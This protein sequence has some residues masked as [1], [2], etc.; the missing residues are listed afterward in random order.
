MIKDLHYYNEKYCKK[1]IKY[2]FIA[3]GYGG[4]DPTGLH[5]G[6]TGRNL[7][8]E[9]VLTTARVMGGYIAPLL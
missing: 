5:T 1:E 7:S 9:K 4:S 8:M 3:S 6:H 2:F